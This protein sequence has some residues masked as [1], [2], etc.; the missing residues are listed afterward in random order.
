MLMTQVT[1]RVSMLM[2][3]AV[4]LLLSSAMRLK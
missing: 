3:A 2:Y 4:L 1:G